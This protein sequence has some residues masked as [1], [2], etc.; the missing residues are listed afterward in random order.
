MSETYGWVYALAADGSGN[1]YAGGSFRAAGV[2]RHCISRNGTAR[3]GLRSARVSRTGVSAPLRSTGT[4]PCTPVAASRSLAVYPQPAWRDGTGRRGPRS[5]RPGV[6][7]VASVPLPSTRAVLSTRGHF[8]AAGGVSANH[9]ARWNGAAWSALDSGMNWSV[10]ELAV[11]EEGVLYAGGEFIAAGGVPALHVARWNGVSWATVGSGLNATVTALAVDG[12]GRLIAG[13]GFTSAGSTSAPR[14]ARWDGT[15]WTALGSGSGLDR[16]VRSV[17]EDGD[18][19]AYAGADSWSLEVSAH[20]GL[21]S[22]M[23]GNGARWVLVWIPIAG[24]MRWPWMG[25]VGSTRAVIYRSA[26][27]R[28]DTC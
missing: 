12:S 24:C 3:T 10:Y 17:V 9:I 20:P 28:R 1:L 2:I 16:E 19:N 11:D 18:G 5:D 13:G 8:Y 23:G 4:E 15:A 6:Q 22:G 7:G 26:A 25:T 27:D 21:P 14:V